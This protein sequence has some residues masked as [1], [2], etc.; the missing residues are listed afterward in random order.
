MGNPLHILAWKI[1]KTEEHERLQFKVSQK[2]DI[3][4]HTNSHAIF[5]HSE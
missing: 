5:H 3:T 1:P 4:A 2:S